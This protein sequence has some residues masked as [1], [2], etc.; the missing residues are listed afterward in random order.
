MSIAARLNETG[1][2]SVIKLEHIDVATPGSA[3]VWLEQEAIGVNFLDVMHRNGSVAISAAFPCGLGLEGAG[4][5]TAV[6]TEVTNVAVGDRVAY[7]LGP[8]G[9]YASG[10]TYPAERLI[11]LPDTLSSDD[12]AA[13]LFKG[14]T[15]QYLLKSTFNVQ[16]D[17]VVLLYGVAGPV[18]QIMAAWANHLGAFVIGVVSR[19]TSV[20]RAI[21]AGC[22]HVLVW[23]QCDLAAEVSRL[24]QKRMADVVYDG[25]GRTTFEASIQ[26]LR[27]RGTMVSIGASSG[28]PEPV[29]IIAILNMKSLF[30]TR[31]TLGQHVADI[32]EYRARSLDVIDAFE[33]G[34]FKAGI[35][36][37]F[38]LSDV[39]EAQTVLEQGQANGAIILRP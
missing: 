33:S 15:A 22:R 1:A 23:G 7:A 3:D 30:L 18:G 12:A 6:G 14:T 20:D 29:G 27:I 36:K 31:P 9:S 19:K 35:S 17:T 32:D 13:I 16:R 21:A 25:I 26:S 5:V 37:T 2:P 28:V 39:V 4:R 8:I 38:A 34:V 24:T 10:R 11:R